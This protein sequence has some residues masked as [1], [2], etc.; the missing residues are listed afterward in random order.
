MGNYARKKHPKKVIVSLFTSNE[1]WNYGLYGQRRLGSDCADAQ[2]DQ[3]LSLFVYR[4]IGYN[5]L[6]RR[7]TEALIRLEAP[8]SS[9]FATERSKIV[10]L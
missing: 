3:S 8:N 5:G 4:I 9:S 2:S 1:D 6:Y 10:P 7:R